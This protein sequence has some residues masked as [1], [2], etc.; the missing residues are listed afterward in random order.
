MDLKDSIT[1]MMNRSMVHGSTSSIM[2]ARS[3][4]KGV[5]SVELGVSNLAIS[6]TTCGS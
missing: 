1:G 4:A 2:L 5:A 3:F 6:T